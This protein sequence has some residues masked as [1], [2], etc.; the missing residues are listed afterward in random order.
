M[1]I[2]YDYATDV[3]GAN[4]NNRI[5]YDFETTRNKPMPKAKSMINYEMPP[6][7]EDL[8]YTL[9]DILHDTI[10]KGNYS[11]TARALSI[12]PITAKRW[13]RHP[14]TSQSWWNVILA[15]T[16]QQLC[17]Q[18]RHSNSRTHQKQAKLAIAQLTRHNV[19]QLVSNI[20]RDDHTEDGAV[21]HLLI[22][23]NEAPG[24]TL[25]TQQLRLPAYSGGYTLRTFRAAAVRLMLDKDTEGFGP[26]KVTY[27]SIP[28]D[29]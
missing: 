17:S 2:L 14:P 5:L 3:Y 10:Y 11:A 27:Y 26:D 12:S 29:D 4:L 9:F 21:R 24:Q 25:S 16:I 22:K 20:E 8:F 1:R 18:M 13:A 28:R 6:L 19:S 15:H 23:L 7:D